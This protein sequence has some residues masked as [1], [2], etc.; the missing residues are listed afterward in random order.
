VYLYQFMTKNVPYDYRPLRVRLPDA[1]VI[2]F[3]GD[4]YVTAVARHTAY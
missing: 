4:L 2:I 1:P 3:A